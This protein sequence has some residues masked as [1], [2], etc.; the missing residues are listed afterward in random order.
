MKV[1]R[2]TDKDVINCQKRG[3]FDEHLATLYSVA[4]GEPYLYEN[5]Y[6]IYYDALSKTV[7]LTLFELDRENQINADYTE[8][9][10]ILTETFQPQKIVVTS[11]RA[12]PSRIEDYHCEMLYKDYDYQI[13][14]K[15]FDISLS[16][17]TYK[18]LRYHVNHAKR[19]SYSLGI[20]KN[21]T[22]AHSHIMALHLMKAREYE[23]WDYLLYLKLGEYFMKFSSPSLFNVFLDNVLIGFDV[24]DIIGNILAAPLGFYM[25]SPSIADFITYEELM[26][27]KS[28]GFSW[29]DIGWACNNQ[30]LEE[31]KRKWKAVPKFD[32]Y[33][34][35]YNKTKE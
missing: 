32:I 5:R 25:G 26:H 18:D 1:E 9:F 15:E 11:P 7:W 31:F 2:L 10:R 6:L 13:N 4:Y 29:F 20:T 30:G 27:A 34:Q 14:L 12:L 17:G 8:C 22:P 35:E 33:M 16:G 23:L 21:V 24:V 28:A 3:Y 19:C